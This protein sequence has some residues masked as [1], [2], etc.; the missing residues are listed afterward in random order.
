M[1]PAVALTKQNRRSQVAIGTRDGLKPRRSRYPTG[2][3]PSRAQS[4]EEMGTLISGSV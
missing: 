1:T 3:P 2:C 4:G